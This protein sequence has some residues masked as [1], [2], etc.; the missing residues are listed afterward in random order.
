M[1]WSIYAFG[2]SRALRFTKKIIINSF[3]GPAWILGDIF[4]SKYV[5]AY[6]RDLNLVG[7]AKAKNKK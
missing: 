2:Y 7:F 1:H 3:K 6:N 4:L 5:S